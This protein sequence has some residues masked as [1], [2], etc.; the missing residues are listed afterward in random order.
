VVREVF[1][2]ED[3]YAGPCVSGGPDLVVL[4]RPGFDLK[5]SPQAQEV[6][7]RAG[8]TGMHTWD[9]AFLL[10]SQKIEEDDL[11][12][13]DLARILTAELLPAA[14]MRGEGT[15]GREG[16]GPLAG[17]ASREVENQCAGGGEG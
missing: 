11:W 12:I 13:G 9:D 8:L 5:G 17:R 2:A 1:D 6:F 16:A 14:E 7:G 15:T 4:A 3:I 10:S